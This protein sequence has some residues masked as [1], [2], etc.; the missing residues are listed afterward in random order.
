[1]NTWQK[2]ILKP[3]LSSA[4]RLLCVADP[5]GLL[6]DEKILKAI[7]KA[8]LEVLEF[9]EPVLFR[10]LYESRFRQHWDNGIQPE[11]RVLVRLST[12]DLA[13]LPF[14]VLQRAECF[15]ISL[16]ELF[17]HFPVG[18][19]AALSPEHR[20]LL[21]QSIRGKRL[22][23][24]GE[25]AAKAFIL[26][27]VFGIVPEV[28]KTD[29]DL[30]SLLLQRHYRGEQL[31]APF[32]AFLIESLRSR[33]Q[34]ENLP[35][36]AI[37]PSREAFFEFL[38]E[39]WPAFLKG[40]L[41]ESSVQI[42][43]PMGGFALRYPGPVD[44][45]FG[46]QAVRVYMDN[47]FTEGFLQPAP[48]E[49]GL[50]VKDEWF[51]PGLLIDAEADR[52]RKIN[53]FIRRIEMTLPGAD[54]SYQ[55]WREFALRWARLK[56]ALHQ[57]P[58][59]PQ[60]GCRAQL[61]PLEHDMDSRFQQWML[62]HYP[63][64]FNLPALS[65]VMVHHIPRYLANYR[66]KRPNSR[67]ALL[68][69][70]GLALDQWILIKNGL[71][72]EKRNQMP[73]EAAVFAWTPTITEVSRQAIFAGKPPAYFPA[74]I[75]N[76]AK[77]EELWKRFWKGQGV[78]AHHIFYR[79]GLRDAEQ[80]TEL[81]EQLSDPRV[82]IAGLVVDKVDRIMHGIQLGMN[83]LYNQINQ[84]MQ[85][86][87]LNNLL[88]IFRE[89]DFEVFITSDHG[90]V[91]AVGCGSPRE[92]AIANLRGQRVRIYPNASLRREIKSAF[93]DTLEWA[94]T[95]LPEN[96]FPLIAPNRKAFVTAGQRIVTHGGISLEEVIV[97]FIH[98]S[99]STQI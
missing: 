6:V 19:V 2:T 47:L 31:P 80:L 87:F 76:T 96:N 1:M 62:S 77:E 12:P 86:G 32:D 11:R 79:K 69:I 20:E 3:I 89:H 37:I 49:D 50:R 54:A 64:L 53:E 15:S 26:K 33:K 92:G 82:K 66:S 61:P 28:I 13:R 18:V 78:S 40:V 51:A 17:P 59:D 27:Q 22:S 65:P 43:E 93:P 7:G 36:H 34:F 56:G 75:G 60:A 44:L 74:A 91:E 97:P 9:E 98:M 88:D 41:A 73:H 24:M 29:V 30:L 25:R 85:E 70:D 90:N 35:L 68:I 14:D 46:D 71:Q 83:G 39:R 84:W 99:A 63:G 42:K 95:G 5:D 23:P 57:L 48:V 10:Y 4:A 55:D 45:P 52:V 58:P 38:Q 72:T 94:P 21:F 8:G 67:I 16:A 81:K